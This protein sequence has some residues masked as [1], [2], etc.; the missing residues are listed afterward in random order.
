MTLL[1]LK[2]F[3]KTWTA[4]ILNKLGRAEQGNANDYMDE[5]HF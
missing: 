5:V 4:E 3:K 2:V 1:F